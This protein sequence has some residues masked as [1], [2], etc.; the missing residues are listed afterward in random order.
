MKQCF[1]T[2][3]TNT[4]IPYKF[5]NGSFGMK[6]KLSTSTGAHLFLVRHPTRLV[7]ITRSTLVLAPRGVRRQWHGPL[8]ANDWAEEDAATWWLCGRA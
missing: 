4:S 3:F 7:A 5:P 8:V 1:S 6:L 2:V